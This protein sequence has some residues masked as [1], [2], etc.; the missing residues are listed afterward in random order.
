MSNDST[1]II[2]DIDLDDWGSE[3]D[4]DDTIALVHSL[5][6]RRM[7]ENRLEDLRLRRE[8]SEFD[9]DL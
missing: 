4:S 9:F 2:S 6:S 7:V 1:V 8:T 3:E 5:D